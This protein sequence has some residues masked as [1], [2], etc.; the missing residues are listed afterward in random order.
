[1]LITVSNI[2][3]LNLIIKTAQL[4]VVDDGFL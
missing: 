3:F 2:Y 4:F 1:M